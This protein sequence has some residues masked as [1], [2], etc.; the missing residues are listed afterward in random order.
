MTKM[1]S[2][3]KTIVL[4]LILFSVKNAYSLN[5]V[6][7]TL[8]ND[9]GLCLQEKVGYQTCDK[10]LVSLNGSQDHELHIVNQ[11]L[12]GNN[13]DFSLNTTAEMKEN[14]NAN[15]ITR[16]MVVCGLVVL[17]FLPVM[18]RR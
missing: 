8:F 10:T 7:I 17:A 14:V 18:L 4:V 12:F 11:R 2:Y 16:Y 6:N 1:D 13:E 3:K 9:A 5:D 15:N